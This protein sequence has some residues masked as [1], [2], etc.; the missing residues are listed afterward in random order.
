[1]AEVKSI[2]HKNIT[3]TNDIYVDDE[4]V[5]TQTVTVDTSD[6]SSLPFNDYIINSPLYKANRVAIRAEEARFEDEVYA[7]QDQMAS[8]QD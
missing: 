5:K 6:L 1:M 3:I 7:L 4:L 2:E 8:E